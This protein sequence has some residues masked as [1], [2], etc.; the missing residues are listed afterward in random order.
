MHDSLKRVLRD[1]NK[2]PFSGEE[3]KQVR[4][5]FI[6]GAVETGILSDD[7]ARKMRK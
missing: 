3:K 2:L 1:V 4:N 6:T 5:I 7:D